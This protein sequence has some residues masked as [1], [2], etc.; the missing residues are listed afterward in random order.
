MGKMDP[1]TGPPQDRRLG[2]TGHEAAH[3]SSRTTPYR[4]GIVRRCQRMF[5]SL[6]DKAVRNS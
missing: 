6:S 3:L 4:Q 5:L 2:V 1:E